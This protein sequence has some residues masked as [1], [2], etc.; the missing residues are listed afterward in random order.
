MHTV[1]NN[2]SGQGTGRYDSEQ[3]V[4]PVGVQRQRDEKARAGARTVRGVER[5]VIDHHQQ[6][7]QH[8]TCDRS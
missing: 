5:T 3:P 6:E 8:Y 7:Q 4:Q 1:Y 2:K